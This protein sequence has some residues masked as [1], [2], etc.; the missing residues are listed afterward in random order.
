MIND[1]EFIKSQD[2]ELPFGAAHIDEMLSPGEILQSVDKQLAVYGLEI[3][4]LDFEG[5]YHSYRIVEVPK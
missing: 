4:M 2:Q 3:Q 5:R 1:N